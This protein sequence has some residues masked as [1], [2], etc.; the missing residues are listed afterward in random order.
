M[1]FRTLLTLLATVAFALTPAFRDAGAAA[2]PPRAG[3]PKLIVVLVVDQLR[4]DYLSEYASNFSA[5]FRRLLREGAWFTNA[6]YPYLNTVTCAGHSTIGTGDFPYRHGM[7]LN[8]WL[9]RQTGKTPFC[10]DDPDVQDISYNGLPPAQGDS[11]KRMLAPAIGEQV[12]ARGGR[13][14]TMSLKPRS[15]VPLAGKR[16]DAVIWFD[17]RGGWST[18]SAYTNT[19]VPF[20]QQFIDANPL[21]AD[22]GKVWEKT[23]PESAY[24]HADDGEG[25]GLASGWTRTF[26]HPLGVEGGKPD[27]T[28]YSRW[29]RSPFADE[30]L[31]RMA[32]SALDALQLGRGTTTDFLGVSFSSL[33]V[34]G[35]TYGPK[36]HEVQDVL[37]RLDRTIG[38]LLEHLDRTVGAGNY[39]VGLSADHGVAEVPEQIKRGGRQAGKTAQDALT[40]TLTP[41]LGPGPHVAASNYTDIY[42]TE[43]ANARLRADPKLVAAT[44]D[45]LRALPAVERVFRGDELAAAGARS[46]GD[47]VLRAAALSYHPQRSGDFII[48]P[49][50]Q[51]LLSTSVTTHGTHHPY[52]QRVPVILFGGGIKPGEYRGT[53]TPAD[54]TP[55]LTAIAGVPIAA[56]DGRVLKEALRHP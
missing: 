38:R 53:A 19:P 45:A 10:T 35:H 5:G 56:C 49:K 8:G 46:S 9:D 11:A 39:V 31:G 23:L 15:A 30:Y 36:S 25:E 4:A 14:V 52:D 17:D 22:Y 2:Q 24:R 48:V 1:T 55:T 32:V 54:L 26:P 28:F 43:A 21:S 6:A 37:V 27:G 7:I 34:V 47:P 18:S 29:Q 41:L 33:D 12:K 51:W 44:M 42:L 40:K 20:L 13:S 3:Q 50:E 16:A